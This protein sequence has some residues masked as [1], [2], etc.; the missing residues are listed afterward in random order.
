MS[1]VD[2]GVQRAAPVMKDR[3]E[4]ASPV[5]SPEQSLVP[6]ASHYDESRESA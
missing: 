1:D 6:T 5:L 2:V 3:L 4:L